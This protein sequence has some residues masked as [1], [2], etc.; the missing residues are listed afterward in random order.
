MRLLQD[1]Y[2]DKKKVNSIHSNKGWLMIKRRRESLRDKRERSRRRSRSVMTIHKNCEFNNWIEVY[3]NVKRDLKSIKKSS[4]FISFA[5]KNLDN[6]SHW[7][8]HRIRISIATKNVSMLRIW[9]YRLIRIRVRIVTKNL[10]CF[11]RKIIS[12]ICI[13][14]KFHLKTFT[15]K[16][17]LKV[18][19]FYETFKIDIMIFKTLFCY[20]WKF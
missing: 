11:D 7:K 8:Y 5:T 16:I 3:K 20:L 2:K 19:T 15:S 18:P 4:H 1:R 6:V 9:E 13:E 10:I 17:N 14:D 12:N